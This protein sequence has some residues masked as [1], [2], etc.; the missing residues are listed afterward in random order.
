L[1]LTA[2]VS[3][4]I[5]F[6]SDRAYA[7][8]VAGLHSASVEVASQ[9][10]DDRS[11]AFTIAL[12]QVLIKVSGDEANL[13]TP[14][15]N[16]MLNSPEV[17]VQT[18]S[19][20]DN[21]DYLAYL[22]FRLSQQPKTQGVEKPAPQSAE[23]QTLEQPLPYIL[24]VSFSA[25]SVE[26]KMNSFGLPI[27]GTVRPS[28]LLWVVSEQSGER[29]ITSSS[30]SSVTDVAEI[31]AQQRGLPIYF[32]VVDLADISAVDIDE[33]WGLYPES[34][35]N[36][37]RRYAPDVVVMVR[38]VDIGDD[39]WSGDWL[40]HTKQELLSGSKS[41]IDL[42]GLW[43]GLFAQV[44]SNL[45][46]RYAVRKSGESLKDYIDISVS[47]V[48]TFKD[49]ARLKKY[50]EAL[51]PVSTSMLS[52]VNRGEVGYRIELA[53]TRDQF[54]EHIALGGG[55]VPQLR[56]ITNGSGTFIES[57]TL[58]LE[59]EGDGN[60]QVDRAPESEFEAELRLFSQNGQDNTL[61][62][63]PLVEYF[64]WD[65]VGAASL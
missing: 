63:G 60:T 8:S 31:V 11:A 29:K 7:A 22:Q 48:S 49:Y 25:E 57:D 42:L 46:S 15:L 45:A 52:W 61:D 3:L 40:V 36:A 18:Y 53:G 13:L 10:N 4:S 34:V 56:D 38:L 58:S 23:K 44:S 50:L 30:D 54:Y 65:S 5:A 28:I 37:S 33:L 59:Q 20:R 35:E 26:N 27:W 6:N 9:Q 41:G 19:Y 47:N 55:L 2:I 14:G 24:D 17:Y 62:S 43:Q 64:S 12:N 1:L 32:P 39:G 21:P 16:A 51:P